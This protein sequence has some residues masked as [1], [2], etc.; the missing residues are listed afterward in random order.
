M[1]DLDFKFRNNKISISELNELRERINSMS[2]SELE[3]FLSNSWFKDELDVLSIED[4]RIERIKK[5][6]DET[7]GRERKKITFLP[8]VAQVVAAVLLLALFSTTFYLYNENNR[9]ASEELTVST[10]KNERANI[11][12]PDGTSVAL[13]SESRLSY[14]P[15]TYNNKE[16]KISFDGEGY[17]QVHKDLERSFIIDARGMEVKVLG[18][19]FNLSVRVSE[20]TAILALE[21]GSV[22][23]HS[24][25]A[26]KDVILK[27]NQKAI[28]DQQTGD[29]IIVTD[30]N[31]EDVS[32]WRKG[33]MVFRNTSLSNVIYSVEE[34]YNVKITI[35]CTDCLNETFTGTIPNTN[36]NEVLEIIEK[37]FHL[38][39]FI[40]DKE[41][42]LKMH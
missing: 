13:N 25:L 21:E 3:E 16:R 2:D 42:T 23:L 14:V 34:N 35:N 24:V 37:S 6:I 7:I 19:I 38:K 17:F 20:N 29:I 15:K 8:R 26:D 9:L 30:E 36:L 22:S 4:E 28:L 11:T 32:A 33:D 1:S 12:L 5:N 41:I 31:I 40:K 18:T 10:G 39:A 27:P